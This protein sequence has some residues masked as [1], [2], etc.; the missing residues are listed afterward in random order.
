[1]IASSSMV[2]GAFDS[3]SM[4]NTVVAL[5]H[6]SYI[7]SL[8]TFGSVFA[9]AIGIHRSVFTDTD[10]AVVVLQTLAITRTYFHFGTS[11][12]KTAYLLAPLICLVI[13]A[14]YR[15]AQTYASEPSSPIRSLSAFWI[16][17]ITFE[18]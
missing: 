8:G 2:S 7:L 6:A 10:V 1:M 18:L 13:V 4:L 11:N 3:E 15:V 12:R 16:M 5:R 14:I 9:S 17:Q